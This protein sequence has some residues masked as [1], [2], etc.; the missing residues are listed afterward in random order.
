ML[1]FVLNVHLNSLSAL[2][3]A[4]WQKESRHSR[5]NEPSMNYCLLKRLIKSAT[6]AQTYTYKR[7]Y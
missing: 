3:G 5:M 7:C 2:P 1:D 4:K 6:S